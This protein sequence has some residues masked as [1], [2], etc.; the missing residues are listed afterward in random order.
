VNKWFIGHD[1]AVLGSGTSDDLVFYS[2]GYNVT[3]RLAYTGGAVSVS[4]GLVVGDNGIHTGTGGI[5]SD[6]PVASKNNFVAGSAT[7]SG[8]YYFGS[9]GTKYLNYDGTNY[10]LAGGGLAVLGYVNVGANAGSGTIYFGNTGSRTLTWDGTSFSLTY[11]TGSL[12][13]NNGGA[14][15]SSASLVMDGGSAVSGG[16]FTQWRKNGV[17]QYSFG[18]SSTFF[19]TTS[20]DLVLYNHMIPASVMQVT[21][22][23]NSTQF[24]YSLLVGNAPMTAPA[25]IAKFA[26]GGGST[27]YG[28]GMRPQADTTTVMWF[29]NAGGTNIGSISQTATNV[30]FNTASSAELKEDLKS[31]DAGNIID[32][33]NV[34]DFKWKSSSERAYGVI[35]QQ[36]IEVYPLAVT[37]SKQ[38][39]MD[40]DAWGVDYSKYIPVLLQELKTL[41]ARVA[42]LE[43]RVDAKPGQ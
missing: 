30:A 8:A 10:Q 41:R 39:G 25:Q 3:L 43:G 26:Y 14:G 23:N 19:A 31:F 35:A 40:D 22:A 1:S 2:A 34:Y 37:H 11:G 13:L 4:G 7:V 24:Y 15:N 18:H 17:I 38:D 6:G 29:E 12:I 9:S 33:T 20:N 21:A 27:Q 5:T 16:C 28:I 32:Q 42:Q 36:A